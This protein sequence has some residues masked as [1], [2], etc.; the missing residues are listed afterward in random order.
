M[1]T[2]GSARWHSEA[3]ITS[4]NV[5]EA[6]RFLVGVGLCLN[7]TEFDNL[8]EHFDAGE[9]SVDR[10]DM[11]K[12][13][14]ELSTLPPGKE[15]VWRGPAPESPYTHHLSLSGVSHLEF[16]K[17]YR[18]FPAHWGIPP[19][20]TMKG[21]MGVVRDLPDGYGKGN[22]PMENW[23]KLHLEHDRD[24]NTDTYGRKP[25]PFGNYS[26][27][28]NPALAPAPKFGGDK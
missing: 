18:P 9:E 5:T 22:G 7:K 21:H 13:A 25:Y 16:G 3:D 24:T 2:R 8:F 6:H 17:Q 27:G 28:C 23:V 11:L 12:F 10:C 26:L 4:M 1:N 14:T 20:H 15:P 19:N